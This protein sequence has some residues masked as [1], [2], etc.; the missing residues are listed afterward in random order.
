MKSLRSA[1]SISAV[2]RRIF[3]TSRFS[4]PG[5]AEASRTGIVASVANA[6]CTRSTVLASSPGAGVAAA[7]AMSTAVDLFLAFGNPLGTGNLLLLTVE[8]AS[9][10]GFEG[11]DLRR[12][13]G[14]MLPFVQNG[15]FGLSG[16]TRPSSVVDAIA[17]AGLSAV[18]V[19]KL[20]SVVPTKDRQEEALRWL[21]ERLVACT[22]RPAAP[23][24]ERFADISTREM[25]ILRLL[26]EGRSDQ[27]IADRLVL[28]L[29]TVNTHVL[30]I[31][32]KLQAPNRRAAADLYRQAVD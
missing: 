3:P 19:E 24:G 10:L 23:A 11:A 8:F 20:R 30:N 1:A 27:E 16:T 4:A 22:A 15:P 2:F 21:R 26:A 6:W 5:V 12:L 29:R 17:R 31:R 25:D 7:E 14:Y 18:D 28:G 32:R 13:L 9:E